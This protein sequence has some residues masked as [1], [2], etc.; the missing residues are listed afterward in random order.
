MGLPFSRLVF[1]HYLYP[2]SR[3]HLR[4]GHR[5]RNALIAIGQ[6]RGLPFKSSS[7]PLRKRPHNRACCDAEIMSMPSL[8]SRE[9]SFSPP[10]KINKRQP[11]SGC[12]LVPPKRGSLSAIVRSYKAGVS[13]KSRV[14][15]LAQWIWQPRFHDHLLRGDAVISSVCDY[16]RNNPGN[17]MQ[18]N[19]NPAAN[20]IAKSRAEHP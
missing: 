18:D 1:C 6:N 4:G 20:G 3:L 10:P 16:I 5:R 17:W 2:Q 8:R 7:Q 9:H 13:Y 14:L 15:G 11:T 19:D 12:G